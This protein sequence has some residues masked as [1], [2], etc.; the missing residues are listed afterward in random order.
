M[1]VKARD[2]TASD[3]FAMKDESAPKE[4]CRTITTFC[5]MSSLAGTTCDK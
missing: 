1:T 4:L 2:V 5:E 3:T